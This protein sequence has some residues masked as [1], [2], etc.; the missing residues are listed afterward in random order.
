MTRLFDTHFH[1]DLQKDRAVA[2]REI[3]DNQLY[4]I[5]VTNLPE[6]YRK[7]VTEFSSKYIRV[8]LGF[9]PELI[10]DYS[11]QLPLMWD[12]LPDARYVGEVGLDFVDRKYE[13]E[14]VGFFREL[15][16]RCKNDEKK[17]ITIHSRN[18]VKSVLDIIGKDFKFKPI[19]H[20]YT[21]T[22]TEL[23]RAIDAG[24]WFSIN[25]AMIHSRKFMA[26]L[27]IIP[28][29]RILLETDS[30]FTISSESHSATLRR[31]S[32]SL[33]KVVE[34]IDVWRNFRLLLE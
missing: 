22:K 28:E 5:A 24:C 19:M 2:I 27:P 16:E 11:F 23:I 15:V 10:H 1:L 3:E 14:Q 13:V 30:P 32:Y 18:A 6:L 20:W 17:I 31:I 7:E 29:D 9:H 8:A 21:G 25:S 33:E 4:T 26:L 34:G 12:L